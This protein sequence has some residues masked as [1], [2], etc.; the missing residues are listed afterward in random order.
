M[1]ETPILQVV[2]LD[3][4]THGVEWLEY[5]LGNVDHVSSTETDRTAAQ[6]HSLYVV[7]SNK[8]PLRVHDKG[9]VS[10]AVA[11][12]RPEVRSLAQFVC[13][14]RGGYGAVRDICDK[15]V[16]SQHG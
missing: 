8:L 5:L 4:E 14:N 2:G 16:G 6:P 3:S 15:I 12:A 7:N 13:Q 1:T 11:D 9:W 10:C